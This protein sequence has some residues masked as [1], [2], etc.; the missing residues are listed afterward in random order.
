MWKTVII[1]LTAKTIIIATTIKRFAKLLTRNAVGFPTPKFKFQK[2]TRH[3]LIFL[4]KILKKH[5][6]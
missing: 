6:T 5:R 4:A 3:Y 2:K 1:D